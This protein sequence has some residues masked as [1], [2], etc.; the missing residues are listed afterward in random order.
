MEKRL[1]KHRLDS[2]L[3]VIAIYALA[4]VTPSGI[5]FDGVNLWVIDSVSAKV[6]KHKM[7][8][9]LSEVAAYDSP[10]MN[11]SGMFR[12]GDFYYISDYKTGKIYKV[13]SKDFTASEIYELPGF[14]KNKEKL[15]GIAWDG[16]S[17]WGCSDGEPKQVVSFTLGSL[18]KT[19]L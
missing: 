5:C 16:K 9:T 13:S 11:P 12:N 3:S 17:I 6:Y 18:K 14:D 7:D 10:A 8:E 2:D 19:K 15:A 1:Y 4:N